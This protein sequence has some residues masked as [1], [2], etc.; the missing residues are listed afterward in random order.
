MKTGG[1]NCTLQSNEIDFETEELLVGSKVC[2]KVIK[3]ILYDGFLSCNCF[4]V[5]LQRTI[6]CQQIMLKTALRLAHTRAL[7]PATISCN[8]SRDKSHHV[9]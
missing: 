7:V 9:N 4:A 1:D 5:A 6:A 3:K 8:K 2:A